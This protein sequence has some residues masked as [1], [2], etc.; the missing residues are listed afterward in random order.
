MCIYVDGEHSDL[1]WLNTT[2]YETYL[3]FLASGFTLFLDLLVCYLLDAI[4]VMMI[5]MVSC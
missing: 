2:S 1:N 4:M 5:F 3:E